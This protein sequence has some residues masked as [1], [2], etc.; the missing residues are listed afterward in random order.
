[1]AVASARSLVRGGERKA[2]IAIGRVSCR[3]DRREAVGSE[4]Q[5]R[6]EARK[7]LPAQML[8]GAHGKHRRVCVENKPCKRHRKLSLGDVDCSSVAMIEHV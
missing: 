2:G 5:N 6:V 3:G 7:K 8:R 4:A 1:M